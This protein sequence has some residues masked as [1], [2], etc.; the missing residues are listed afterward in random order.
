MDNIK[1]TYNPLQITEKYRKIR[2]KYFSDPDYK[3]LADTDWRL[4]DLESLYEFNFLSVLLFDRWNTG[5]TRTT[6]EVCHAIK[7][8]KKYSQIN[9]PRYIEY[10]DEVRKTLPVRSICELDIYDAIDDIRSDFGIISNS[11]QLWI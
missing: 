7:N 5:F 9:W 4:D 1:T 3:T 6:E 11:Q 8:H 10:I 2:I